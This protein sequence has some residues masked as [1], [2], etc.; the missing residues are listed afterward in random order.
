MGNDSE[1]R[2]RDRERCFARVMQAD[3]DF[4]GYIQDISEL[5]CRILALSPTVLK[6]TQTALFDVTLEE[7]PEAFPVPIRFLGEVRWTRNLPKYVLYGL[8][9][10]SFPSNRDADGFNS[11]V[12][13]YRASEKN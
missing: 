7:E 13:Y 6:V 10:N 8:K 11:L 5:G 2:A 1:K 3:T 4:M 12:M 9:V